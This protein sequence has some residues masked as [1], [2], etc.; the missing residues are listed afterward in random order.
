MWV[1]LCIILLT[2]KQGHIYNV[3][4][5]QQLARDLSNALPSVICIFSNM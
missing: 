2:Q 5:I 3:Y 4:A 1:L